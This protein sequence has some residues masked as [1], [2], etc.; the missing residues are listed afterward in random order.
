MSWLKRAGQ[1]RGVRLEQKSISWVK[2]LMA[3]FSKEGS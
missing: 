1:N 2:D 3:K